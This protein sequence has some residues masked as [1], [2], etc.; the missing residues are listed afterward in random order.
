M[1]LQYK[2]HDTI[3]IHTKG[4]ILSF[5]ENH[6]GMPSSEGNELPDIRLNTGRI[7]SLKY[8]VGDLGTGVKTK[9]Q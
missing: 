8:L 1:S 6:I 4:Q 5:V 2:S 9:K 3:K 7:N